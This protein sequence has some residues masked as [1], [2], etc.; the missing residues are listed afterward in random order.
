VGKDL[1]DGLVAMTTPNSFSA[2]VN[3]YDKASPRASWII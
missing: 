2:V 1:P 3:T